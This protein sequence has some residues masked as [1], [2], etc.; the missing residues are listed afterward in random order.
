MSE[1]GEGSEGGTAGR[2]SSREVFA[3]D[4]SRAS[5]SASAAR[6][7]SLSVGFLSCLALLPTQFVLKMS[8]D[9]MLSSSGAKSPSSSPAQKHTAHHC[10]CNSA[11]SVCSGQMCS[12]SRAAAERGGSPRPSFSAWQLPCSP[13]GVRW[14]RGEEKNQR[15]G[16]GEEHGARRG[17]PGCAAAH[18]PGARAVQ[19]WGKQM[20]PRW[21][22]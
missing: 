15:G 18:P 21:G 20:M 11:S 17:W 7:V 6:T 5:R 9:A 10:C 14:A 4:G 13:W 1:Q 3:A 19:G 22:R 8:G 12:P 2:G 16:C